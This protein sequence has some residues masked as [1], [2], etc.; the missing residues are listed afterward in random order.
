MVEVDVRIEKSTGD[1]YYPKVTE[2]TI[3]EADPYQINSSM[4]RIAESDLSD[5]PIHGDITINLDDQT[6]FTGTLGKRRASI[7]KTKSSL[8]FLAKDYGDILSCTYVSTPKDWS[9]P[10]AIGTI[11]EDLRSSFVSSHLTG[12]NISSGPD[13]GAYNIPAWS[14]TLL[15]PFQELAEIAG[16]DLFIDTDADINFTAKNTVAKEG[17]SVIEDKN[18]MEINDYTEDKEQVRNYIKVIGD[19][20]YS[21][22]AEDTDSQD[23]YDKREYLHTD[24]SLGSNTACQAVADALLQEE[25]PISVSLI[26]IGDLKVDPRDLVNVYIP[27][28][29]I[30]GTLRV[31]GVEQM[32]DRNTFETSLEL[33]S[34]PLD[35]GSIIA[36]MKRTLALLNGGYV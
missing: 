12:T 14:K 23:N 7:S 11:L 24:P 6:Y 36:Q 8:E 9:T 2:L 13:I 17:F 19:T 28:L 3:S 34:Q 4:I 5:I 21:A 1:V 29:N 15:Q 26:I 35:L 25:P 33:G 18:V 22:Y 16:Y 20:G 32:I 30:D 27:R 31:T 10:I